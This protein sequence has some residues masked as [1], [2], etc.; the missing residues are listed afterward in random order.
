MKK[1]TCKSLRGACDEII[2]GNTPED[3]GENSKQHALKMAQEGDEAHKQA[4]QKMMNL[5]Q[6]EQQRW[7]QDF[8]NNFD[9][10]E[11]A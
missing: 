7:Y 3:M 11:D 1:T 6:E 9:S 5:S 2:T 4:M 8:I 10:L